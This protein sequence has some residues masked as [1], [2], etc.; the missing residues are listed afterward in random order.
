MFGMYIKKLT[1]K[2]KVMDSKKT[3]TVSDN[4]MDR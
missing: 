2:S 3:E 4:E 1:L